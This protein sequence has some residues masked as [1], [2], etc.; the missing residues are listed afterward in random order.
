MLNLAFAVG[1]FS[2]DDCGAMLLLYEF[3]I[4]TKTNDP[5]LYS[6]LESVWR[7]PDIESRTLETM[8]CKC[9]IGARV[10]PVPT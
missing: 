2:G 9:F 1:D 5:S 3:E 4:K 6:F 7:R 8:A 10:R